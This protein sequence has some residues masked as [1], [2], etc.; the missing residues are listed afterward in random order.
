MEKRYNHCLFVI[1][2]TGKGKPVN[3]VE[4]QICCNGKII[5]T[6]SVYPHNLVMNNKIP[7]PLP[8]SLSR[9]DIRY[10][11]VLIPSLYIQIK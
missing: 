8:Y 3:L 2:I 4:L 7:F 10:T 1:F 11:A 5:K 9:K 6:T